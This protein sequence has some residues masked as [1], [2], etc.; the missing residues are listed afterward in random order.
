[1]SSMFKGMTKL[2]TLDITGIDTSNIQYFDSLFE[3]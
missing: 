3:Q 2:K 1:M